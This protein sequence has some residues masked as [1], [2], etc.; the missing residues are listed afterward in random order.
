MKEKLAF[1]LSGG[2]ARGALQ[3]G[4][5][6]ALIEAGYQPAI[7]A[8][9]S[10]GSVNTAFLAINGV[11]LASIDSLIEAW[12]DAEKAELLP[13]NY[14]WLTVRTLF[15]RPLSHSLHRMEAFFVSHGLSPE[16]K[17][18]DL[19]DITLLSVAADLNSGKAYIYGLDPQQTILEGVLAST[20]LPPWIEPI[21]KEGAWLMD[22]G[23]VSPLPIEPVINVGATHVIALSLADHRNAATSAH[24]FGPFFNKLLFTVEKRQIDTEMALANSR[25]ISV[26]LINLI[27]EIPVPL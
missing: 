26:H 19:K 17:Y 25:R 3:V 7:L 13:S 16:K 6:K 10:I 18:G 14:L 2:G 4:A 11:T 5:L 9:T 27:G 15:Q 20:A 22:G 23:A 1:A 8:G 21:E 12:R 24:G